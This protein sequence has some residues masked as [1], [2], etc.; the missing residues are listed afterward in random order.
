MSTSRVRSVNKTSK[1]NQHRLSYA[2]SENL[3]TASEVKSERQV[4]A[5]PEGEL[6]DPQYGVRTR[7]LCTRRQNKQ[8]EQNPQN[9]DPLC[10]PSPENMEPRTFP[11]DIGPPQHNISLPN[12]Q[13]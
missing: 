2:E 1:Q 7:P 5:G 9:Q 10:N 3:T 6:A 4:G 13:C 11:A 12:L 8:T